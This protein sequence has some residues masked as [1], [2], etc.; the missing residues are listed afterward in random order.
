M[1]IN[2]R[3]F[4]A[5]IERE[6][7]TTV[8]KAMNKIDRKDTM[9]IGEAVIDE[10]KTMAS[11]GISPIKQNGR[12]PAYKWVGKA[13][14]I[15][16]VARSLTGERKKSAKQKAANLK[17]GKY[18]YSVQ[19]KFPGKRERPVNL[20]LSGDF[21]DSLKVIP[22]ARGLRIGFFDKLSVKKEQGHREGANGQP[23]RPIL[24]T[25]GEEFS[26]SIYRR[27]VDTLTLVLRN[28]FKT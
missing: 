11:K 5:D 25:R 4:K 21:L 3:K 18:P 14:A 12:F 13:N 20:F 22:L 19:R 24:P 1:S 28:K 27:V 17:K 9:K 15:V 16:K 26:P 23:K 6:F 2:Y 8:N 7:K 10:I